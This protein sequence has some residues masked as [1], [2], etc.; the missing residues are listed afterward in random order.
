MIF[1]TVY[2]SAARHALSDEELNDILTASHRNNQRDNVTGLLLYA[3][4]TF[5]QVLEGR[6]AKVHALY[7]RILRDPRHSHMVHLVSGHHP[8]RQ[9]S[10]WTMGFRRTARSQAGAQLP[11]FTDALEQGNWGA[12]ESNQVSRRLLSMLKAFRAVTRA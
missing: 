8:T 7:N 4:G 12:F 2:S 10:C 3:E 9:F 6:E 5:L 11:G 1:Y